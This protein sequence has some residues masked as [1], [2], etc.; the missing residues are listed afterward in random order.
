MAKDYYEILGVNKSATQDEIKKAYYKLAHK[1]HPHKG[2]DEKKM[3]E[4]NEAWSV[5]G[6]AEKRSQYDKFGASFNQAGAGAG[7]F[8]GFSDFADA[9]RSS[10]A[11]GQQGANFSFDFGDLG[12]IFGDFF[13]GGSR[14]GQAG[15]RTRSQGHDIEAQINLEFKEA[16]F[17]VEKNFFLDKDVKCRHCGGSGAQAGSKVL[18]CSTCRGTGQVVRSIGFGMGIPSVCS[19][20][21]GE[22][23]KIEKECSHC[24]GKGFVKDREEINVKI[25]AGID[26]G[27]TIRLAQQGAAGLR[28]APAGDLYLRIQ[29][30]PDKR[31]KRDGYNIRT[32]SEISFKQAALGDKIEI[33]TVDGKVKLKIPEGTQG[34]KIFMIKGRGV[35]HLQGRGRGDHLVEVIVKVPSKLNRQ[36]RKSIEV[37]DLD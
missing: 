16:I 8:G 37:L 26:N 3:K 23:K 30:N 36:Q 6:N 17:G 5:L 29:V 1:H 7:G 21:Q 12:D 10:G 22:G 18:T 31:F 24:H 19:D 25:P 20:C 28:N 14:G 35:P 33:E 15:A 9:F 13:G 27:Q 34:G 11:A 32:S 2:G 4:V